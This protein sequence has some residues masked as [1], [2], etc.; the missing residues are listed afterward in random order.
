MTIYTPTY[1]YI[2]QHSVTGKLYFGKTTRDPKK[3]LG[4]G[5]H[6][7]RH[8]KKH[9]KEHVETLWYCLF[10]D[11]EIISEFALIFSEQQNI[12]ESSDWLN[13]IPENGLDGAP[14]GV[15]LS[16]ETKVKMSVA[17]KGKSNGPHSEETKLKISIARNGISPSDETRRKLS[18]ALKDVKQAVVICPH[19]DK[20]GGVSTM[21]RWHFDNCNH[22]V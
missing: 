2:K 4:S 15:S 12:V 18:V 16:K 7:G 6:W 19:C 5:T 11:K 8:I 10:F 13:I 3:Y 22:I 14:P 20:S 9:G 17:H 21:K 1:L